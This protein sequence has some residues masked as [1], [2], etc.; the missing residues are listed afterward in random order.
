MISA[1]RL[2]ASQ[3][4]ILNLRN[5]A[6]A[7]EEVLRDVVL[8]QET[9]HP[10]LKQKS[11]EEI[12]KVLIVVMTSDRGLCGGFNGNICRFTEQF[13]KESSYQKKDLFFIGKKGA[14]YFKFRGIEGIGDPLLNLVKEISYPLS[15]KISKILWKKLYQK[16]RCC[17][18]YLQ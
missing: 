13:L 17:F 9:T 18:Y 14:S 7:L 8:S 1:A 10:F 3:S 11:P 5:Y 16:L 15:A 6:N 2:R 4:R 12:K